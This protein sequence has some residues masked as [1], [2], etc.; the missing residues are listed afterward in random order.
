MNK[1]IKTVPAIVQIPESAVKVTIIANVIDEDMGLRKAVMEL[2][3]PELNE[4][5]NIGWDWEF[6]NSKWKLTDKAIEELGLT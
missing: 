1:E 3:M 4:A 2:N 5:K 6:E